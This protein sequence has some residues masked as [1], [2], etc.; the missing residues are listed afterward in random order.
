[1][2]KF[3]KI[4]LVLLIAAASAILIWCSYRVFL[5]TLSREM[6]GMYQYQTLLPKNM[7]IL[8]SKFG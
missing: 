7:G 2:E 3:K 6:P 5:G 4:I 8:G 1:M